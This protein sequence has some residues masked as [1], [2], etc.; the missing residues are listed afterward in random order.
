MYVNMLTYLFISEVSLLPYNCIVLAECL[1]HMCCFLRKYIQLLI[2][3]LYIHNYFP[4]TY[5]YIY[6]YMNSSINSSLS[7]HN[8]KNIIIINI[9]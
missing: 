1:T 8:Y 2:S 7:I 6:I 4:G 3:Y 5:M 9:L